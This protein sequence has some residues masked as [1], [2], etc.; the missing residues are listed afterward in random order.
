MLHCV[1]KFSD[2]VLVDQL[3][4]RCQCLVD[5]VFSFGALGMFVKGVG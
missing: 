1:Y 5:E 4:G 2:C 3:I